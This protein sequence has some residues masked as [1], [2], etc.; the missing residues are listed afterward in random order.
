MVHTND[1]HDQEQIRCLVRVGFVGV[2]P[3]RR[4][5]TSLQE[6][7]D[8]AICTFVVRSDPALDGECYHTT[9]TATS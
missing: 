4:L 2:K 9:S 6:F 7:E 5:A 3:D 1:F 8:I